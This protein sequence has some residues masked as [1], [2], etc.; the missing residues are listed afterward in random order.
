VERVGSREP[1]AGSRKMQDRGGRV[2]C[3]GLDFAVSSL[4]KSDL[5]G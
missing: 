1:G 4:K 2:Q 3:M 5:S